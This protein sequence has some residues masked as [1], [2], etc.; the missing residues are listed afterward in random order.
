MSR[1]R[2]SHR[3]LLQLPAPDGLIHACRKQAVTIRMEGDRGHPIAMTPENA[4]LC[5]RLD[6]PDA[7]HHV[8]P[9]RCEQITVW[10]KRHRADG[11]LVSQETASL[12][13]SV[14]EVPNLDCL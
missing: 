2:P 3:A 14:D 7:N 9:G 12:G 4:G 1:S 13:S 10:M 5:G 11:A 6:I 8:G